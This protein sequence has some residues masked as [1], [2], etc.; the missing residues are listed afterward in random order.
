MTHKIYVHSKGRVNTSSSH[1]D[2]SFQLPYPVEIQQSRAFID[3]VHIPNSFETIHENNKFIY[4]EEMIGSSSQKRKIALTEGVYDSSSL[5]TELQAALNNGTNMSLNS[6]T[7]AFNSINGKISIATS[8]AANIFFVW[9]AEYLTRGLWNPLGFPSI[10]NYTEH[11]D[12]YDVLGYHY[13]TTITGSLNN[14]AVGTTHI[15]LIPHHT[16]YIHSSLGTQNSSV[17]VM[18]SSSIIRT[19]C[20]DQAIGRYVHDR[21]V[22]PF[23]YISISKGMLRQMDFR[24]TDWRGRTINLQ[25][26]WSFSI[27]LIPEDEV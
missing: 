23:D 15:N 20:L 12:A 4:I 22:L 7:V 9:T 27:L 24:L 2:F 1:S 18:G 25:D 13:P 11:Q 21:S 6:Y 8:D 19:I 17:G 16:L 5:V 14:P 10:P 3:Q 26:S